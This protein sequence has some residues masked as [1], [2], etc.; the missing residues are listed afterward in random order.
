VQIVHPGCRDPWLQA[1]QDKRDAER[2]LGAFL[3]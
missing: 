3:K 2:A 1:L